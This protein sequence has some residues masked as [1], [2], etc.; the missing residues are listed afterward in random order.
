[1]GEALDNRFSL[2]ND[3]FSLDGFSSRISNP[4]W[5]RLRESLRF[6]GKIMW[7]A[8]PRVA[9][10]WFVGNKQTGFL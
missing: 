3:E 6:A 1:M 4:G 5:G 9:K 8:I 10:R 7:T 2:T